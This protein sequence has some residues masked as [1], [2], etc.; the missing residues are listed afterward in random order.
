MQH[1]KRFQRLAGWATALFASGLLAASCSTPPTPEISYKIDGVIALEDL[2][3]PPFWFRMLKAMPADPA[4]WTDRENQVLSIFG[5]EALATSYGGFKDT[6][7][8]MAATN[9][10]P[11]SLIRR[12]ARDTSI[13]MINESHTRTDT[14]AF[15][16][17]VAVALREEGYT[18]FAAEGFGNG[19]GFAFRLDKIERS[20]PQDKD[21]PYMSEASYGRLFRQIKDLGYTTVAYELYQNVTADPSDSF[22]Q[23]NERDEAQAE[24]LMEAVLR[25]APG[26]KI[27]IHVGYS[28]L[29]ETLVQRDGVVV[30]KWLGLRLKE[31]TGI[32]PLT[33]SQTHCQSGGPFGLSGP[34]ESAAD[35]P[36]AD[37]FINRAPPEFVRGR[38]GWRVE[39]G[40]MLVDIPEA[41]LPT[42]DWHV[43]EARAASEPDDATPMD[44]VL[45]LPGEDVA[46]ALPPGKYRLRAVSIGRSGEN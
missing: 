12:K 27:L 41:L 25:E 18:H 39:R 44:R 30:G 9:E 13:V 31:K 36:F 28:H 20:Y 14:R 24:N 10:D 2:Q 38:P 33:I 7:C 19:P 40:D 34:P 35:N 42:D 43:V 8:T 32:D 3:N 26:T 29:R 1:H 17:D 46:L 4:D 23:I 22:A 5:R 21:G 11:L 15:I 16:G 6:P 45:V 37:I